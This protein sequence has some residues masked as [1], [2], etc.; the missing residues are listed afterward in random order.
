MSKG[1]SIMLVVLL[2]AATPSFAQQTPPPPPPPS[3][4]AQ[5][6]AQPVQWSSLSSDQQKLLGKFSSN[7]SSLPPER[8]Q[9]L[10]PV[11]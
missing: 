4:P 1:S 8:Q 10:A 6:P 3:A 5:A 9:A 2:A 11:Q 7:W